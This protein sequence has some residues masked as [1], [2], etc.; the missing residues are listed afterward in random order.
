MRVTPVAYTIKL[1][2]L[3]MGQEMYFSIICINV[4]VRM[5]N[6]IYFSLFFSKIL[7]IAYSHNVKSAINSD[8]IEDRA[9]MFAYSRGFSAMADRMV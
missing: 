7:E 3:I 9:V 6:L 1:E 5:E 4:A 2:Q 8:S